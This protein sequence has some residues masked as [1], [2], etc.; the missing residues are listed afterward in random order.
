MEN[1]A[2]TTRAKFE[3]HGITTV[4]GMKMITSTTISAIMG[5]KGCRVSETTLKKWQH[6]AE[7]AHEGGMSSWVRLDHRKEEKDEIRKCSAMSGFIC[8]T[9]MVHHM[10]EETDRIME[11]T[12]YEGIGQFNHDALALMTCSNTKAYMQKNDSLKYWLLPL[13]NLQVGTR[14]HNSELI[15]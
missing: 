4:L 8:V 3:K 6:A 2:E 10:K 11:G 5:D 1:I 9:K 7:Q 13:E 12:S 14:Y 15:P